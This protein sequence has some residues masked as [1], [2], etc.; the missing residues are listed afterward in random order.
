V[1]FSRLYFGVHFVS[2][3]LIGAVIGY[4]IGLLVIKLE[5]ENKWGKNVY[6][7]IMRR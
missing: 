1:G 3:V 5:K 7:K 2:D 6:N 4:L